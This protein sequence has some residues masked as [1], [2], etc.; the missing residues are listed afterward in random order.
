MTEKQL[1]HDLTMAITYAL[2]DAIVNEWQT[3]DGET[4][5]LRPSIIG[6]KDQLV[7]MIKLHDN[8]N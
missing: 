8:G 1:I 7:K 6:L 4:V 5:L 3:K 2:E